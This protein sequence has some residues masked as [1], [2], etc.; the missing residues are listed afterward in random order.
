MLCWKMDRWHSLGHKVQYRYFRF[1]ERDLFY[2]NITFR[3]PPQRVSHRWLSVFDCLSIDMMLIDPLTLIYYAWI[4]N[5][6]RETCKGDINNIFHKCIFYS[7]TK[8][9]ISAIQT[10]MKQKKLTDDGK[11]QKE[12]IIT[13]LF[14]KQSTLLLNSNLFLSVLPSF[15]LT[16]EQ[17][18]PLIHRLHRSLIENFRAFLG[19][20]MKFEV[21]NDTS[22]NKLNSIDVSS[23]LRTLKTFYVGDK[24]EN[25]ISSSRKNKVQKEIFTKSFVLHMLLLQLTLKRNTQ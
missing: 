18:E 16:F 3:K 13:K 24:N 8:A 6:F 10:K 25:L 19:C 23:K 9:L 5:E 2:S 22:Y 21:I 14:Y 17:K 4:P 1:I 12:R 7:N 11:K 15:I 20:F